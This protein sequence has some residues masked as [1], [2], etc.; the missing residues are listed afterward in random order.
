M[1]D[2]LVIGPVIDGRALCK[3]LLIRRK[4]NGRFSYY[5][6]WDNNK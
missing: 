1:V 2:F 3:R 5:R 4:K 6:W